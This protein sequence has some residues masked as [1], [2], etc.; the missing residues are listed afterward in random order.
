MQKRDWPHQD[1]CALCNGPLET[2]LHLCLCRPF[3]KAVWNQ[4]LKWEH[5][6]GN[7]GQ[8]QADPLSIIPW[9]EEA[10]AKVPKTEQRR[11]NGL[12]IYTF[13]NLRKERNRRIFKNKMETVLQVAARI[14]EDIEQRM[15]AFM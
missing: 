1:H 7:L 3:A 4:I 2:G 14:K 13:W 9:W 8:Q 6:D 11:F 5:F 12:V 15:R 10:T